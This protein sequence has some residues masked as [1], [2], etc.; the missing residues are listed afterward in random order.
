[1]RNLRAGVLVVGH[2]SR[3]EEAN[4]DVREVARSIGER[5]G[6]PLVVAAFLE[7]AIPDIDQGLSQLIEA[8]A[9][10]IIVHPYFLSPGRH[11]RGDIPAKVAM[12]VN[13]HS[14]LSYQITE[15][16]AAHSFVIDASIE[17]IRE[18]QARRSVEFQS[19]KP[20]GPGKVYLVGAGPGD[21]GLITVK[22]LEVLRRADVVIYDYLVNPELL[23]NIR[24][25][26][27]RIYAGKVG[28]G[29]QTPQTDINNLLIDR[30]RQGK[31]VVR[32][33][34]GDPFLFGR[35][36]EEGQALRAAG[37]SFEFVPGVSSALAVPAYAGI[38]L[39]HR[40]LSRSV[41]IVTG[42]QAGNDDLSDQLR[43]A[44]SADT[45]VVLMGLSELRRIGEELIAAGVSPYT[46]AAVIRWGTYD[47]QETI[48]G[49]LV[50]IADTVSRARVRAPVV[51]VIGEVVRLREQLNWF[52]KGIAGLV[53]DAPVAEV[54][55]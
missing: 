3:R 36:G 53:V 20:I 54:V 32:L 40:G 41:A 43:R 6:F 2:G 1:M 15:P 8:G 46:P 12:A 19:S 21:P 52:E 11:T 28:G 9:N 35:G 18:T 13:R 55:T 7:I 31:L 22:A 17:R 47:S 44:A 29:Q 37:V 34:G 16:L 26:A 45:I 48:V 39:T 27:E 30:A 33:K 51:I 23:E 50:S 10:H 38:P 25:D 49:S 42:A 14:H 5:G 4:A 24:A